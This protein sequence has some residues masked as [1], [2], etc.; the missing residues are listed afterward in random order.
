M[1]RF[2][3]ENLVPLSA[4]TPKP[5]WQHFQT[6]CD[7]PRPSKHEAVLIKEITDWC[8]KNNINARQ[9]EVGNLILSKPASKGKEDALPVVLQSHLDMV[10]QKT[11]ESSHDFFTDS[12]IPQVQGD[13]VKATG[14]TLGADNGIGVAAI[15]A[16]L[17]DATLVHGPIE[18][19]LTVDEEAGMSGAAGLAG[20]V[21]AGKVLLNLDTEEEGE[22]YVG[23]AGGVD[24][25][26]HFQLQLE[27]AQGD[28]LAYEIK[29]SGLQGGHSGIEIHKPLANGNQLLARLLESCLQQGTKISQVSGG[30][31]RNA[32]C[33]DAS[34]TILMAVG[35]ENSAL[36]ALNKLSGAMAVEFS[37]YETHL[38]ITIEK[39]AAPA[40]VWCHEF[41]QKVVAALLACPHGVR[42]MSDQFEGVVETSNNLATLVQSETELSICCLPR[43]LMDSAR[44][45]QVAAIRAVFELAGARVEVM[46]AYPG[47]APIKESPIMT[48]M[49]RVHGQ[50]F[51]EPA[52]IQVIHAGLEC[53]I[54]GATYPHWQMISFGPMIRGAH[55]PDE[56]VSISSVQK[57]WQYL[58]ASLGTLADVKAL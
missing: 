50:C 48:L 1:K 19:L 25:N 14:T 8:G 33:R 30:T 27:A 20:D 58:L 9:D 18:A 54:L 53:G 31:L 39:V 49:Q 4:L 15:L 24:V 44:D 37:G 51:G 40:K 28:Y 55:S 47:W 43:S 29:I 26:A 52:K 17:G 23:C 56:R 34:A 22:L 41:S 16:V 21:L 10:S 46:N 12:I 11:N 35:T 36:Q 42:R 3:K 38:D 13:W 7:I 5:L 6:L 45:A 57:F 32:I 2:S